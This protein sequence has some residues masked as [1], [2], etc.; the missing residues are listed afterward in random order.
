MPRP[1]ISINLMTSERTMKVRYSNKKPSKKKKKKT[2]AHVQIL[3]VQPK[4]T[5]G[6]FIYKTY[7]KARLQHGCATHVDIS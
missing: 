1:S 6:I 3:T 7:F 4:V 2:V 5:I